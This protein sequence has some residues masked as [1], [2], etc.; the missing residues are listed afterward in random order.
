MKIMIAAVLVLAATAVSANA[1]QICAVADPTGTPL[2]LRTKP[3]GTI[4]GA[5][6]NC[7]AVTLLDE[8]KGWAKVLTFNKSQPDKI[9]WVFREHLA[10]ADRWIEARK[11]TD[12]HKG[13]PGR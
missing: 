2:N 8:T 6:H 11:M 3:N 9:G 10:C 1:R 13:Q 7:S 5:L 4:L 12:C